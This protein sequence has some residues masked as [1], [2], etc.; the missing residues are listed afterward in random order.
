MSLVKAYRIVKT[1]RSHNAF[2]GQ[3]AKMNGGRWNSPGQAC[4]YLANSPSLAQLEM[5]VNLNKEALMLAYTL[6]EIGIPTD[7]IDKLSYEQL[8]ENWEESPAPVEL[9]DIGDQWLKDANSALALAIPSVV[10]PYNIETNYLLNP[11][12]SLFSEVVGTAKAFDLRFDQ[13]FKS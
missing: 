7:S 11:N 13:R 9:A 10:S 1:K 8:P 12:H 5:L 4:V 6:F 3:G 2:N